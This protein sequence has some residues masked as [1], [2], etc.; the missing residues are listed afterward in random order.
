MRF[1]IGLALGFGVGFAGAV[2][3]A[4]DRSKGKAVKWPAGTLQGGPAVFEENH[5]NFMGAVK[6]AL[7]TVQEQV[8]EA[9]E[10]AKKAQE[11]AEEELRARYE[12]TAGRRV[13]EKRK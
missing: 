7:R 5:N 13:G 3:F 9:L 2:L 11:E 12:S 10:E 6:R 8:N 1:L 4:P